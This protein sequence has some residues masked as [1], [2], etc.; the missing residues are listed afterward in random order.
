MQAPC[1]IWYT[2]KSRERERLAHVQWW[3][4]GRDLG[5][6]RYTCAI[7]LRVTKEE[8]EDR[9]REEEKRKTTRGRYEL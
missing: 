5:L 4:S 3:S 7:S 6:G 9:E 8:R 1:T 2:Q